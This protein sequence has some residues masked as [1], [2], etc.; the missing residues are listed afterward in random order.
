MK[1][2]ESTSR[3]LRIT[4]VPHL[5]PI[6]VYLED[7][8]PGRGQITLTC[9]GKSWTTFWGA[10]GEHN[11][12]ASFVLK[13]DLDYLSTRLDSGTSRTRFSDDA[14][15]TLAKKTV[16]DRRR[17]KGDGE[18]LDREAARDLYARIE[19]LHGCEQIDQCPARLMQELF[20]DE[21]WFVADRAV[22]PN[23]DHLYLERIL[24]T[25][26]DAL[27]MAAGS[28]P[29]APVERAAAARRPAPR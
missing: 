22:E 8:D 1:L 13:C 19:D 14:L 25:V 4:D 23:P 9:Y 16:C 27:R 12:V 21:W 3:K 24:Q 28:A 17:G 15:V 6:D 5:D 2:T 18:P 26:Q 10:M 7:F 11:D 29:E 20:G